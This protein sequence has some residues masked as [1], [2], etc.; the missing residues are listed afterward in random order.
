MNSQTTT[1]TPVQVPAPTQGT[2]LPSPSFKCLK[3]F[4]E[5]GFIKHDG[6]PLDFKPIHGLITPCSDGTSP[7]D[8]T[9]WQA[10]YGSDDSQE[11]CNSIDQLFS[12]LSW[13]YTQ[14]VVG[15]RRPHGAH[16]LVF[17]RWDDISDLNYEDFLS[18]G[19]QFL[20]PTEQK[21]VGVN[22][23]GRVQATPTKP[24]IWQVTAF[25]KLADFTLATLILVSTRRGGPG[26]SNMA[27]GSICIALPVTSL[28]LLPGVL[29]SG[30][31]ATI[32]MDEEEEEVKADPPSIVAPAPTGIDLPEMVPLPPRRKRPFQ[33]P[34][35]PPEI[36]ED[37]EALRRAHVA[38]SRSSHIEGL[39]IDEVISISG[40]E[41]GD[42]ILNSNQLQPGKSNSQIVVMNNNLPDTS[43]SLLHF[44]A[45]SPELQQNFQQGGI[46]TDADIGLLVSIIS[47]ASPTTGR[48]GLRWC[49]F[50]ILKALLKGKPP[51]TFKLIASSFLDDPPSKVDELI[52]GRIMLKELTTAL[53]HPSIASVFINTL[54][55]SD[56]LLTTAH[57]GCDSVWSLYGGV[58][59]L[60]DHILKELPSI[61]HQWSARMGSF[62]SSNDEDRHQSLVTNL[63]SQWSQEY[64]TSQLSTIG[65]GRSTL[66][67]SRSETSTPKPS[68][69]SSA[70]PRSFSSSSYTRRDSY[71]SATDKFCLDWLRDGARGSSCRN[72]SCTKMHELPRKQ[73]W[74]RDLA[75]VD[76]IPRE[77]RDRLRDPPRRR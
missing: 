56:S 9:R 20:I 64:F 14:E 18:V 13:S 40:G 76:G 17:P 15:I 19:Q 2:Q 30:V 7:L 58:V 11:A 3:P 73:S 54:I 53:F 59:R 68:N 72:R 77:V 29:E 5:T 24:P 35:V 26:V 22:D 23:V 37:A 38:S 32:R 50:D 39:S 48:E 70:P 67:S 16:G 51:L 47:V 63:R 41:V 6:T 69:S 43:R 33:P 74:C 46:K 31:T 62:N 4:S 25:N 65:F 57:V 12:A 61:L 34:L 44:S 66:R 28:R 49:S 10:F 36:T 8:S 27:P 42:L 75:R 1:L 52:L 71:E 60:F 45:L 55:G 21:N